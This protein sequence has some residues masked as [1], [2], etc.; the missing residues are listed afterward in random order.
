MTTDFQRQGLRCCLAL[1]MVSAWSQL[2]GA[3]DGL[4][5]ENTNYLYRIIANRVVASERGGAP[6]NVPDP[7][8][9]TASS[10]TGTP[11]PE[12]ATEYEPVPKWSAWA[13]GYSKSS[14][15]YYNRF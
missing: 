11:I 7:M 4:N 10:Q 8:F 15:P 6:G 12:Q 5:A 3:I 9:A 2:A 14:N 1:A 13:E